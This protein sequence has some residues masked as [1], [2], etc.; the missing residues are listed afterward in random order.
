MTSVQ[1]LSIPGS[2]GRTKFQAVA[3]EQRADAETA[4]QALDAISLKLP[5]H[6][7]SVVVV[8][9]FEED[10]FFAASQSSRLRELMQQWRDCRDAG[11]SLADVEQAELESLVE[12]ELLATTNRAAALA[13]ELKR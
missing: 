8:Q 12:A 11:T 10:E 2:R 4:G 7:T 1:I 6:E 13:A 5:R 3:G 9:P